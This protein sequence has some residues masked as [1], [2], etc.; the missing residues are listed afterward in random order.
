MKLPQILSTISLLIS[1]TV[2]YFLYEETQ[3]NNLLTSKNLSL[4]TEVLNLNNSI[5]EINSKI[6]NLESLNVD[7]SLKLNKLQSNAE[8]KEETLS[9]LKEEFEDMND[10]FLDLY[11]VARP[12]VFTYEPADVWEYVEGNGGQI[13]LL[14]FDDIYDSVDGDLVLEFTIQ[15]PYA[16]DLEG[17]SIDF[18]I[19]ETNEEDSLTKYDYIPTNDFELLAGDSEQFF[20]NIPNM[21]QA[22]F[23]G[24]HIYS[25]EFDYISACD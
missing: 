21:S 25:I 11:S 13:Y 4:E 10:S 6:K 12:S 5:S 9:T 23:D 19:D 8:R 3:T 17:L 1:F 15:N 22:N 2:V 24:I 14:S 7:S 18:S 20:I 16:Q